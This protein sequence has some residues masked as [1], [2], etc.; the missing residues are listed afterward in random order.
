MFLAGGTAPRDACSNPWRRSHY[1][2][3]YECEVS[4]L[5]PRRRVAK[6]SCKVPPDGS[7][8]LSINE[9]VLPRER[10]TE[11]SSLFPP[12]AQASRRGAILESVRSASHIALVTAA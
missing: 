9:Y 4:F 2:H 6:K 3:F 10:E 7:G 5:A 12:A 1:M 11:E 8:H